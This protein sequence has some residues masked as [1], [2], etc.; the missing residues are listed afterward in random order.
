MLIRQAD[1]DVVVY[2]RTGMQA[3]YA[4]LVARHLGYAPRMYD[5]S[6]IDWSNNTDYPTST[7]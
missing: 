5:G 2:C 6:Y 7:N 4:Y 1:H 3:S